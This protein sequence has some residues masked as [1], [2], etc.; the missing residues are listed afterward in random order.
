MPRK[1]VEKPQA[2]KTIGTRSPELDT[3]AR[4]LG[5]LALA[6]SEQEGRLGVR[7]KEQLRRAL[8]AAGDALRW[9]GTSES[10][11]E[12]IAAVSKDV[13]A[14]S[15][16]GAKAMAKD[17]AA[18]LARKKTEVAELAEISEALRVMSEDEGT[19]YPVE[20]SYP[21]T[22][23]DA[24]Y[25]Q[26]TKTENLLLNEAREALSSSES[27]AKGIPSR[28]KLA[29]LMI[30]ALTAKQGREEVMT[31]GLPDFVKSTHELLREVIV[32]LQ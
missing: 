17:L 31:R 28:T 8:S 3:V 2:Q 15:K 11:N 21:Y 18:E 19:S 9:P 7:Q 13:L 24:T 6:Q 12:S 20:M 23:R 5:A 29:D 32:T 4:Q 30:I 16:R 14:L 10:T 1:K 27:I 22:A 25:G 26:V